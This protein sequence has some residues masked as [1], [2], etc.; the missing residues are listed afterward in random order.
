METNIK[1]LTMQIGQ[2]F[3]ADLEDQT[4]TFG[5]EDGF[6][7]SAGVFAIEPIDQWQTRLEENERL[8]V[9]L[10][11]IAKLES[12]EYCQAYKNHFFDIKKI[13]SEA[14]NP[15]NQQNESK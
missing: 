4:W 10:E 1:T 7:V 3:S 15:T 11:K 9:A 6:E 14:L 8:R 5:L 13:A 12:I 2:S